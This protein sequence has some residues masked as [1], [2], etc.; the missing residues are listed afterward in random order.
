MHCA[1]DALAPAFIILSKSRAYPNK[2]HGRDV[3]DGAMTLGIMTFSIMT[4]SKSANLRRS[5]YAT[6]GLNDSHHTSIY[7]NAECHYAECRILFFVV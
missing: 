7:Y 4:H 1:I 3:Q 6:L 2:P 5:A